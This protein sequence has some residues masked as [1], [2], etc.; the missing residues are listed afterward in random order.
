MTSE[1]GSKKA[2]VSSL[3]EKWTENFPFSTLYV[4]EI[5]LKFLHLRKELKVMQTLI[6]CDFLDC[7]AKQ[8][9]ATF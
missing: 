8:M 3:V 4:N 9:P 1:G 7:S 2:R 5:K 6:F